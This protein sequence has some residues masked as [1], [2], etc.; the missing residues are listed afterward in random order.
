MCSF[1]CWCRDVGQTEEEDDEHQEAVPKFFV[2]DEPEH[3]LPPVQL[4]VSCLQGVQPYDRQ[5]LMHHKR[6]TQGLALV[7]KW[8]GNLPGTVS[9][10]FR[11]MLSSGVK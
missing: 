6:K 8:E 3:T 2:G 11:E 4:V 7:G 5:P 9:R 1:V 10:L